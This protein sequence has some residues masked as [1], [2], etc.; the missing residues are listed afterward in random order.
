MEGPKNK[1]NWLSPFKLTNKVLGVAGGVLGA[2][3][4]AGGNALA[5]ADNEQHRKLAIDDIHSIMFPPGTILMRGGSIPVARD[6]T[7][8]PLDEHELKRFDKS[9]NTLRRLNAV[10]GYIKAFDG[11]I[12]RI[13]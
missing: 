7:T 1:S 11:K 6:L 2:A 13:P 10:P 12:F 8:Y 5:D 3:A 9:L 4:K